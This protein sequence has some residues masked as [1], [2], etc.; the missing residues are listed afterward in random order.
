MIVLSGI[1]DLDDHCD[2]RMERLDA[3]RAKV[4]AGLE[5]QLEDARIDLARLRDEI[6]QPA[7][8]VGDAAPDHGAIDVVHAGER[9][10]N[11]ARGLASAEI[12]DVRRD[13][14]VLDGSKVGAR[15]F[16]SRSRVILACSPAAMRSSGAE[17]L[18][19]RRRSSPSISSALLP[20]AKIRNTWP[21]LL[22]YSRLSA[23]KTSSVICVAPRAPACS[24]FAHPAAR[25]PMRGW[26]A[27][28]SSQSPLSSD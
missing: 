5:G 14:P 22:S 20:V 18:A 27:N 3:A 7:I 28:A 15:S 2:A 11:T 24:S 21:N 16:W 12:Q 9:D 25:S 26:W 17:S 23:L 10:S 8:R 19:R 13:H 6:A 4:D 1:G